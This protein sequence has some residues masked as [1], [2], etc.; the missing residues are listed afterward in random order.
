[1]RFSLVSDPVAFRDAADALAAGRGPFALDTERASTYRYDDR[2][3]LVQV[4]R[5]DAGTFLIAPEGHR[6]AV[7]AA[8]APVLSGADWILHAAGEDLPSLRL[9]GLT[10]GTLFDTELAARLAGF[11]RPNLAAMV[12]EFTGVELEKGH[13][14]EDWS[15]T[16]LPRAWQEYAADDVEYLNDLA[17]GLAEYLDR[18]GKL[19]AAAQE[20]DHLMSL[21]PPPRKTW[22]DIK[23]ITTVP[24]GLGT[25]IVRA[26]WEHRDARARATDTSPH[27]LLAS[28]VII[29]IARTRPRTP[30]ALAR[31]PGFPARRRGAVDEWFAVLSRVYDAPEDLSPA[32]DLGPAET[33]PPSK[34]AWQRH[35]PESWARLVA[36]RDG[37]AGAAA[38][39]EIAPEVLLQPAVLRRAVWDGADGDTDRVARRLARLGARPWQVGAAAPVV[40]KALAELEAERASETG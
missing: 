10:P 33:E 36:G 11:A 18:D 14:R 1:M 8:F 17:E 35:H 34:S 4:A 20:F 16:P 22:R 15:R 27:A 6:D 38:K 13:G 21:P 32:A 40:A 24:P 26:L 29:Q 31:I 28:K 2:A 30:G 19:E 7:R 23:G 9:L 39:L 3:F 12:A 5:R 37:V 25:R